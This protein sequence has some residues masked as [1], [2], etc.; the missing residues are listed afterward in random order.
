MNKPTNRIVREETC[1][2]CGETLTVREYEP[3]NH[4]AYIPV[5]V[6]NGPVINKV[7]VCH[8]CFTAKEHTFTDRGWTRIVITECIDN[9]EE[10]YGSRDGGLDR[11]HTLTPVVAILAAFCT[12]LILLGQS[13]LLHSVVAQFGKLGVR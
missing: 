13:G 12:A 5:T 6:I 4:N 1:F 2:D 8:R 10:F 11:G 9:A 3:W 7:A